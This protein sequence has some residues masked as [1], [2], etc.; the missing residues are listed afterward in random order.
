MRNFARRL[1]KLEAGIVDCHGLI[2]FSPRWLEYWNEKF[3]RMQTGED[4][5]LTG[6]TL[7]DI[8]AMREMDRQESAAVER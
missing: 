5:D 8:D 6:L 3:E 1:E 2:R 7:A 4:L